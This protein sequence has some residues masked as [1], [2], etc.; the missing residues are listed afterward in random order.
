M[1]GGKRSVSFY[2]GVTLSAVV[3]IVAFR[4]AA[5]ELLSSSGAQAP[6]GFVRQSE[7]AS[8]IALYR[9]TSENVTAQAASGLLAEARAVA[10]RYPLS[11]NAPFAAGIAQARLGDNNAAGEAMQLTIERNPRN[12]I[13]RTWLSEQALR[14]GDFTEALRQLNALMR[15]EPTLVPQISQAMVP[16][17]FAPDM[18]DAFADAA[19]DRPPWLPSFI[20]GARRDPR[21]VRQVYAL[22]LEIAAREPDAV[23]PRNIVEVI[24]AAQSRGDF[25]SGFRLLK[26]FYPLAFAEGGNRVFDP[27]FMEVEGAAP[28][29]WTIDR[30]SGTVAAGTSSGLEVVGRVSAGTTLASQSLI[31]APGN[32]ALSSRGQVSSGDSG[33]MWVLSCQGSNQP[34][35]A[36]SPAN[37]IAASMGG[38]PGVL[39]TVP[40][41][42]GFTALALVA[43]SQ[44]VG[45]NPLSIQ[46][47]SVIRQ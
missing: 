12:R 23:E 47:V 17:L 10:A 25:D 32:Y 38:N 37:A 33:A 44:V 3:A 16:F 4:S 21:L 19:E 15:V 43:E 1:I 5:I 26:A 2:A 8:E 29:V 30:D 45:D 31:L 13:V 36:A 42:C 20:D 24:N 35:A 9:Q 39:F 7:A 34:I 11:V 40:P 6:F 28:F 18:V 22:M 27:R 14:K 41:G 46:S